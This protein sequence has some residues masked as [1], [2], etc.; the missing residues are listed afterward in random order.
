[1]T[2]NATTT[3]LADDA[4]PELKGDLCNWCEERAAVEHGYDEHN[5]N[6]QLCAE[7]YRDADVNPDRPTPYNGASIYAL[8]ATIDELMSWALAYRP[9][10]RG[11]RPSEPRW[12]VHI[13]TPS[14]GCAPRVLVIHD[15]CQW[16]RSAEPI[17]RLAATICHDTDSH[18]YARFPGAWASPSDWVRHGA[19]ILGL[20]Y[21]A[22][23][24]GT[25]DAI[26]DAAHA[27][28]EDA[29]GDDH[30]VALATVIIEGL[31]S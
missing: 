4:A 20:D 11:D 5:G 8:A 25:L 16:Y 29:T 18:Q 2:T 6:W 3:P 22:I 13:Q 23:S 27:A 19:D 17:E 1:M 12:L 9:V 21:H 24:G 31:T 30:A 14:E 26:A 10:G 28:D 15:M 7:C